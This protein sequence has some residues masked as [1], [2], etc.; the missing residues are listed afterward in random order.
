MKKY[1]LKIKFKSFA[2]PAVLFSEMTVFSPCVH[3]YSALLNQSLN[4]ALQHRWQPLGAGVKLSLKEWL[5][6]CVLV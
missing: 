5:S 1:K 2:L 6:G 3:L 4:S